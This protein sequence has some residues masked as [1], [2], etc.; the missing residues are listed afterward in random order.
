MSLLQYYKSRIV[1][2][3]AKEI[4]EE[5]ARKQAAFCSLA[6]GAV[7]LPEATVENFFGS[8]SHISVGKNSY[9]RGRLLTYGHGGCISIGEWCYVGLNTEIWSMQS[10]S[11]GNRV[12]ISH[13]VN[14]HDGTAHSTNASEDRKSVV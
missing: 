14:I 1:N 9:I 2:W 13:N 10:I 6:P 8:R 11:I 7:L 12:L 4:A 3:L 5:R